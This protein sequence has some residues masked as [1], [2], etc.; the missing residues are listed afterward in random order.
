MEPNV[1]SGDQRPCAG[2]ES[3]NDVPKPQPITNPL[4]PLS[5]SLRVSLEALPDEALPILGPELFDQANRELNRSPQTRADN[6][7]SGQIFKAIDGYMRFFYRDEEN[8]AR[9]MYQNIV[10]LVY[11]CTKSDLERRR[12]NQ[13]FEDGW[14]SG[15]LE[16]LASVLR[17][18]L[19]LYKGD[20]V[21]E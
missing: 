6:E 2:P 9:H 18:D 19:G 17:E 14:A 13:A 10:G 21:V 4:T 11:P 7:R 20:L 1:R 3:S 8:R 16:F 15:E 12:L 5:E